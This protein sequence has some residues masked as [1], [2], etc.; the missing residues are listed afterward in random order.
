MDFIFSR[1]K[2]KSDEKIYKVL[3]D[4]KLFEE[5]KVDACVP[6]NPDHNLDEEDWFKIEE[7]SSKEYCLD[8]LDDDF[9]SKNYDELEREQF[10]KIS[11]LVSFQSGSSFYFQK[12]TPSMFLRKKML[13]FGESTKIEESQNRITL[14]ALPDAIYMRDSDVLVFRNLARISTIFPGIDQLYREATKEEVETFLEEEIISLGD[15]FNV[16]KVSKPNRKRIALVKDKF[17]SFNQ[18]E[19][20]TIVC[21]I[22]KYKVKG[23]AF[24]EEKNAFEISNDHQLKLLLYG[25]DERFFSA[26]VSGEQRIANSIQVIKN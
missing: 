16:A 25:L 19:K 9:D 26:V 15:D 10:A 20:S 17:A 6:Y 24:D 23:L 7:F 5:V 3:S 14:N 21:Y 8:F 22:N 18:E 13:H 4:Q 2:G 1:L 11:F 12:V